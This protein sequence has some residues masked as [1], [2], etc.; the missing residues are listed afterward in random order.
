LRCHRIYRVHHGRC[1]GK[2]ILSIHRRRCKWID[3]RWGSSSGPSILMGPRICSGFNFG[4][5]RHHRLVVEGIEV[6]V[7]H[8]VHHILV[9]VIVG[10]GRRV[11]VLSHRRRQ[12]L[13]HRGHVVQLLIVFADEKGIAH[14]ANAAS[15][16]LEVLFRGFAAQ[17]NRRDLRFLLHLLRRTRAR[18]RAALARDGRFC[19]RYLHILPAA[20]P[21]TLRRRHIG[22]PLW[23]H[24]ARLIPSWGG[25][26]RSL[27]WRSGA[28]RRS[29]CLFPLLSL[30]PFTRTGRRSL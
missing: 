23:R 24:S 4:V 22:S 6:T 20:R 10:D 12:F 15:S 3:C 17:M 19:R 30:L 29:L 25:D 26:L 8:I 16:E 13:L 5:P 18:R 21:R 1:G 9:V 28:V 11:I 2:A 14:T 27:R 7:D